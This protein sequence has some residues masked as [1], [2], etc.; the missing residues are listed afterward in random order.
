MQSARGS[1]IERWTTSCWSMW[2]S[3]S[4]KNGEGKT[5]ANCLIAVLTP[6]PLESRLK[7]KLLPRFAHNWLRYLDNVT[8]CAQDKTMQTCG[9]SDY[10]VPPF[11]APQQKTAPT[12]K[13]IGHPATAKV[14]NA[15]GVGSRA[16]RRKQRAAK[17][18][19]IGA[20]G[21]RVIGKT[22]RLHRPTGWSR[23]L[24]LR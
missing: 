10:F 22:N 19:V 5:L 9:I 17:D 7:K 11:L 13:R 21:D 3:R 24:G 15:M 23:P 16:E 4:C 8:D 2:L 14:S 1:M 12:Q 20:S 6:C 18:Q